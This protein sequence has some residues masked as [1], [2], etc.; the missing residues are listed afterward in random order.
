M[1]N[2][3]RM[4]KMSN[5]KNIGVSTE[6]ILNNHLNTYR[7]LGKVTYTCS[8]PISEEKIP[9]YI[10]LNI[11]NDDTVCYVFKVEDMDRD[12]RKRFPII[13]EKPEFI[14]YSPIEYADKPETT[15]LLLSSVQEIDVDFLCLLTNDEEIREAIKNRSNNKI[16]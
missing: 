9:D 16:L 7:E 13:S 15:W 1:E 6:T 12:K 8:L 11:G 2:K 14:K 4:L 5:G 3:L 10:I